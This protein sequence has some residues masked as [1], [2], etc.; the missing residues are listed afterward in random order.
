MKLVK[1]EDLKI[2]M[3]LANCVYNS[4]G[5][6]L[7]ER[8]NGLVAAAL[9]ALQ[10]S[11]CYGVYVL[12]PTE[13]VPPMTEGELEFERQQSVQWPKLKQ[14]LDSIISGNPFSELD[15]LVNEIVTTS[16]KQ[17]QAISFFQTVRGPSDQLY[18]HTLNVASIAC[19]IAN[20]MNFSPADMYAITF[21][22]IIHDIGKL[23]ADPEIL[24]K[25][26][27]LTKEELESVRSAE[28]K[29]YDLITKNSSVPSSIRR[30]IV[31]FNQHSINKTKGADDNDIDFDKYLLGTKILKTADVF[32]LMTSFRVYKDPTSIYS[33]VCYMMSSPKLYSPEVVHALAECIQVLPAGACVE[34]MSGKTA[35][36]LSENKAD[37]RKPTLLIFDTN[38]IVDLSHSTE[39]GMQIKDILKNY[40]HRVKMDMNSLNQ[41]KSLV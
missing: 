17:Q 32:D 21:A 38:S 6:L 25:P 13:P 40:D 14:N 37:L 36:V 11:D 16:L 18:K 31:Q 26:S 3:R 33:T 4:N 28:R 2:G 7:Y 20:K 30:Y 23:Y 5:V 39:V 22:A 10:N 15:P 41:N 9:N 12:D 19:M 1:V 34:L 29:G 8:G 24:F 35:L 27:T